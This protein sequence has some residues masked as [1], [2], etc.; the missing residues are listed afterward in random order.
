[1]PNRIKNK[2]EKKPLTPEEEKVK[3]GYDHFTRKN[4]LETKEQ[5]SGMKV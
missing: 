3:K 4:D 2:S 1:L 5:G